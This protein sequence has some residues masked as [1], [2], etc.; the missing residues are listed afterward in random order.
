MI[1][2]ITDAAVD[3]LKL[4]PLLLITYLVME[5]LEHKAADQT[6][7]LIRKAGRLGPLC[8]AGAGLLP[9]C[10]FS[11]AAAN[12]YAARLISRGTLIAVFLA[13]SDEMLPIF[14]SEGVSPR[15]ILHILGVKFGV[16]LAVG[17]LVDLLSGL[18][19]KESA[20]QEPEMQELC[21]KEHCGCESGIFRSALHHTGTIVL[22]LFLVT[23]LLN[24][25][26]I[27]AD[28]DTLAFHMQGNPILGVM[29]T[30]LIGLI[31]NCASSVLITQ[32]YLRGAL[33]FGAA[34]AGLLV[35]S[36]MG[37][38]VLLR[39]NADRKENAKI[40]GILYGAGVLAGILLELF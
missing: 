33:G 24:I 27:F 1:D 32:L 13:T 12:L 34:M 15:V 17:F 9:Q 18:W 31:P 20:V 4:I 5:Y 38:L 22:F 23:L 37:V 6:Q 30:A 28:V 3:V 26:F 11:A 25:V 14:I 35:G 40:V 2:A 19:K 39:M 10:G 29:L 7:R 8:G 21:K 36:G 16:G